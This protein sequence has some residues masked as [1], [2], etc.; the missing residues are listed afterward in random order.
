MAKQRVL[1]SGGGFGGV[2]AALMLSEDRRFDVTLLTDNADFRYYPTLFRTATGGKRMISSIPLQEIFRDKNIHIIVGSV[3]KVDHLTK[4]ITTDMKTEINYDVVIFGL[5]VQTNY[6]GIKGLRDYSYG[7]KTIEDAEEL[8]AHLHK[9]LV[10]KHQLDLNYVVIGG[11]PT[12]IELAGAL[13]HYLKRIAAQHGITK[14]D[15]HVCLVEAAPRLLPRMPRDLS[16]A[17]ARHLR[18][19]GVKLYLK[20]TVEA[21]T[22]DELLVNGKPIKSHTIV[23]TAGVANHPFFAQNEFQLSSNHK[24]R[25]D[26]YLQAE[27]GMYVIGDNADTPYSGMAQ[28]GL[29]DGAYVAANLIRQQNREEIKPYKA[30]KPIYVFPAG[31]NWAAVLWG[32]FRLYGR[33]GWML[34]KA[35]DL[36]AYHDYE[37]WQMASHRWMAESEYEDNCPYCDGQGK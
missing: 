17:V 21:Q 23:W 12:G 2:K 1:I 14:R 25:V 15:I 37:P 22:A 13:P 18:K 9:Q 10:D 33:P 35:A 31:D 36:V 26:Q 28:T 30:K 32:K 16:V 20:S 27:P 8:K 11:G 34:R 7:I 4:T 6:F 19:L 5:G 3:L 29:H 24:V